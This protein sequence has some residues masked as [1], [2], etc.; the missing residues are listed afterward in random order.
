MEKSGNKVI[1]VYDR[2]WNI[3]TD[4]VNGTLIKLRHIKT[5][6]LSDLRN[7][8]RQR[9]ELDAENG[10]YYFNNNQLSWSSLVRAKLSIIRQELTYPTE[11][12]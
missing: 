6:V 1:G 2:R 5:L 3:K 4:I 9:A 12:L 8:V 11:L 10:N 7:G